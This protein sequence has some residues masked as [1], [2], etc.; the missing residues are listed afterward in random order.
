MSEFLEAFHNP[1]VWV[2]GGSLF[3]AVEAFRWLTK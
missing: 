1:W 2:A 3:L